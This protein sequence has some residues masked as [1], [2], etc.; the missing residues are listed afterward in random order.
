MTEEGTLWLE[1][2]SRGGA[3]PDVRVTVEP[4]TAKYFYRHS[5]WMHD[6]DGWPWVAASGVEGASAVT[7]SGLKPGQFTIRL[8]FAEPNDDATSR[9]FA[10]TFGEQSVVSSMDIREAADGAMRSIVRE[11]RRVNVDTDLR[12]NLMAIEGKTLLCG[13]EL[14]RDH[15]VTPNSN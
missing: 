1:Y 9:K 10:I 7:I 15:P 11:V 8:H 13:V 6:G 5:V 14:I 2:P 3:S 4:E 12:I